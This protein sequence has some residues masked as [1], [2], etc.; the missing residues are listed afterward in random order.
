MQQPFANPPPAH[1]EL[2]RHYL[3]LPVPNNYQCKYCGKF[4]SL[5]KHVVDELIWHTRKEH[6]S[7][8]NKPADYFAERMQNLKPPP[9]YLRKYEH[10]NIISDKWLDRLA[11]D[12]YPIADIARSIF[13]RLK[14]SP[15]RFFRESEQRTSKIVASKNAIIN[16]LPRLSL[17]LLP[18]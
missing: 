12:G 10:M 1:P 15:E 16:F 17:S 7:Y 3:P 11:L 6:T 9:K 13:L 2:S 5:D 14:S 8:I 18:E 4:Y